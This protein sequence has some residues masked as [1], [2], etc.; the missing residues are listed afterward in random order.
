MSSESG[1]AV[2]CC[3]EF[4]FEELLQLLLRHNANVLSFDN[5]VLE[6]HQGRD[7]ADAVF[8]GR[9]LGAFDVDLGNLEAVPKTNWEWEH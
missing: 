5:T 3:L 1:T 4:G 9:G 7:A 6:Q 2:G 8:H